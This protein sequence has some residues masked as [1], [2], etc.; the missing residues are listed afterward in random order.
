[1]QDCCLTCDA[2]PT[3]LSA[4]FRQGKVEED[5]FMRAQD[6]AKL[7]AIH[8][9]LLEQAQAAAAASDSDQYQTH[10]LPVMM[11]IKSVLANSDSLSDESLENLARWKLG[12]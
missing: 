7:E 4:L 10:I 11:E 1:M 2:I 3:Y 9:K 12:L 5:R 6:A 8:K